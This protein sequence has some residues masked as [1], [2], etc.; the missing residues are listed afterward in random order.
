[1]DRRRIAITLARVLALVGLVVSAAL[2]IEYA[3][4]EPTL[5]GPGGGCTAV[6]ACWEQRV[7]WFSLPW[8]GLVSFGAALSA[9]LLVPKDKASKLLPALG[10]LSALGGATLIALQLGMCH[11]WCKFCMVTDSSAILLGAALLFGRDAY[12]P[13]SPTQR[14]LFGGGAVLTA[15]VAMLSA[16]PAST[17]GGGT[18]GDS[19]RGPRAQYVAVLPGP[20]AREQRDGVVTI[21]EFADFECPF[22]RRQHAVLSSVIERYHG[23]V[24]LVRK[25]LP[26]T[27]IHP[28]AEDAAKAALCAEELGR[29]EAMADRLFRAE[30]EQLTAD[31]TTAIARELGLDERAFR[32]C[33]AN[34]RTRSHIA[35]DRNAAHE[36]GVQGLPTM[37]IGHE[38]FDGLVDEEAL[39]ESIEHALHPDAGAGVS[40]A[41]GG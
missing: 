9:L 22:C 15:C 5:C 23:R 25:Q 12:E 37:F 17:G 10:A 31:G 41:D 36:C 18:G 38:R 13:A 11:S 28:H 14:W 32:E 40:S 7:K 33:V 30:A 2:I 24:R 8:F 27:G 34:D 1:M 21:V 3:M 39:R 16:P 4:P 35:S 19:S 29:G 26:L 6:R 20:V